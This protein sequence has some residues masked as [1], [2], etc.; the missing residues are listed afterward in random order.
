[1]EQVSIERKARQRRTIDISLRNSL[2]GE[3]AD[4]ICVET[5]RLCFRQDVSTNNASPLQQLIYSS[6]FFQSAHPALVK[7]F[8]Y[9]FYVIR[10]PDNIKALFKNS[11]AC[12]SIPF[13][14]FALG[15][16]FGLPAKALRLYDND[17][18]GGNRVP[19]PGSKVEA[20][21]RID[22]RVYH[23]MVQF[24]EG[25]GLLPFWNRFANNIT[26]QLYNL[27]S[28]T[29]T[30]WTYGPDLMETVG[31]EATISIMN[32][33]CGKYLLSLN[34]TFL[35]DYWAFDRNLQTYLQ[36]SASEDM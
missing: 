10:G 15:Y 27:H 5:A 31:N 19:H 13:V 3:P 21:N 12:S 26:H 17:D 11:G 36:G 18:S 25:K 23:S 4:Y 8:T 16:A 28:R 32:A 22:Y 9:Q 14:K 24:L 2:I 7:I 20:R 34:P 30:E 35:Q 1:M 33:L 29:G 6:Q